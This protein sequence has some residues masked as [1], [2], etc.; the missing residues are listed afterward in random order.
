M[1]R[2]RL[3]FFLVLQ[4]KLELV[5]YHLRELRRIL[6]GLRME[7]MII[8]L[9]EFEGFYEHRWRDLMTQMRA[10]RVNKTETENQILR[11]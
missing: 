4:M 7:E 11:I 1:C 5:I 2:W 10:V 6:T 9:L 8:M 3:V